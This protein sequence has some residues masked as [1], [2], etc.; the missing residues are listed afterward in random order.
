MKK[1]ARIYLIVPVCLA[2]CVVMTACSKAKSTGND[3]TKTPV[4]PVPAFEDVG[5]KT[6]VEDATDKDNDNA[7]KKEAAGEEVTLGEVSGNVYS[8]DY[9]NFEFTFSEDWDKVFTREEVLKLSKMFNKVGVSDEIVLENQGDLLLFMT[10]IQGEKTGSVIDVHALKIGSVT[11]TY[12]EITTAEEIIKKSMGFAGKGAD[13]IRLN[14]I[15]SVQLG[16]KEFKCWEQS[17]GGNAMQV[18]E[19]ACE[20]NGYI[21]VF[22]G[23]T[24][25]DER[26]DDIESFLSSINFK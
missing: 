16:S 14:D 3:N 24:G 22:T 19:Y 1:L 7:V 18:Y 23:S 12:G 15:K 8:N 10:T 4:V 13:E 5:K 21:I 26:T 25:Y 6:E 2:L 20:A 9:F 11:S 17:I